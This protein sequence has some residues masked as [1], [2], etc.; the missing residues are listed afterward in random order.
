MLLSK[1]IALFVRERYVVANVH[2][3]LKQNNIY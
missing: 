2:K 3:I 1:A